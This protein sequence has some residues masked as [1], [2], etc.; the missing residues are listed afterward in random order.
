MKR[1]IKTLVIFL[2]LFCVVPV[3]GCS[4]VQRGIIT[5][6]ACSISELNNLEKAE[7]VKEQINPEIKDEKNLRPVKIVPKTSKKGN[8]CIFERCIL[9]NLF[10]K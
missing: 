1:N 7:T 5:G 10:G 4:Q 8:I 6:G 3:L 2:T 9:K